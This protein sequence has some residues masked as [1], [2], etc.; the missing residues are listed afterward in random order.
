VW[1]KLATN[2]KHIEE[3]ENILYKNKGYKTL[4]ELIYKVYKTNKGWNLLKE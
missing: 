2:D 1:R 4:K 3:L